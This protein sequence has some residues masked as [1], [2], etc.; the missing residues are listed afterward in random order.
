MDSYW[1]YFIVNTLG[2]L[3]YLYEVLILIRVLL[4]W[5]VRDWY[6]PVVRTLV[7]MTDPYLRIF[8]SFL[9][10]LG[11]IDF[12]PFVAV[13]VLQLGWSV[14]SRLLLELAASPY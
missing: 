7:A 11:V 4:S 6:H 1:V 2:R 14:V 8:R 5:F 12:S 3:V 13:L 9:P 10:P